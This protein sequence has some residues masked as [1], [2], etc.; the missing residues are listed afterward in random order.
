M[1]PAQILEDKL[2]EA[3]SAE[4]ETARGRGALQAKV[5]ELEGK[6][7]KERAT[8]GELRKERDFL[9]NLADTG[10]VWELIVKD[11]CA[12]V[13]GVARAPRRARAVRGPRWRSVPLDASRRHLWVA[14]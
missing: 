3:L 13:L 7:A 5:Q 2:D 10:E 4:Q 9:K 1:C 6:L 12:G 11:A 14:A 8:V